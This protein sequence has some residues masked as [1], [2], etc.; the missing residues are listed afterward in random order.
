MST[1]LIKMLL[2]S[3]DQRVFFCSITLLSFSCAQLDHP[4]NIFCMC[5]VVNPNL[6]FSVG[7]VQSKAYARAQGVPTTWSQEDQG[8]IA[9]WYS[10]YSAESYYGAL[11]PGIRKVLL[12]IFILLNL[13]ILHTTITYGVEWYCRFYD[14]LKE[15]SQQTSSIFIAVGIT[16]AIHNFL[17]LTATLVLYANNSVPP[18]HLAECTAI[19]NLHCS[20]SYD[21]ALYKDEL[22]AFITKM[23]VILT[24]II[25][26]LLV[27]IKAPIKITLLPARWCH[28][29]KCFR[30]V[31]VILLWNTFV[32]IQIWL[33]LISLPVSILLLITPLQALPILCAIVLIV[34]LIAA[35]IV[36]LLQFGNQC[37]V[38]NSHFGQAC[39]YFSWYLLFIM[40]V[41]AVSTLYFFLAPEGTSLSTSGV[42]F[43]LLPSI[44]LSGASW[45]AKRKLFSKNP[46]KVKVEKQ[47]SISSVSTVEKDLQGADTEQD[48]GLDDLRRFGEH[49]QDASLSQQ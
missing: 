40:L 28:S 34:A 31:Q 38:R 2:W 20:P 4:L 36:R 37:R 14:I 48:M 45:L 12:T 30:P 23:V 18:I 26:E 6:S 3:L 17:Y 39:G 49:T 16:M 41:F 7:D 33:G 24:A 13:F 29:S 27:A 1:S 44:A 9:T 19:S 47:L 42:I 25:I 11:N 8:Y 46:N 10:Y 35:F 43:S 15:R 21:S 22:T 32:F 5:V